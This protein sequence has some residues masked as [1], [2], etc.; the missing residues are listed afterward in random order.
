MASYALLLALSGF[1]FDMV[2][3]HIGFSPK[4]NHDN[5]HSFWSLNT[6][7]GSFEIQENKIRFTVKWGHI[8]LNSFACSAFKTKQIETITVG[9]RKVSFAVK[10]GCVRFESAIDIKVDEALCAIV[11]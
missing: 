11:K 3:G 2:K 6:G 8:C 7:W 4:I 9:D 10:D 1:E 5:F